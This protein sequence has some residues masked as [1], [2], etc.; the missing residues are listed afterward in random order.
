MDKSC[1]SC[2][3]YT[4]PSS[5]SGY[6]WISGVLLAVIPKCP[7]CVLAYSSTMMLCGEGSL[8]SSRSAHVS[9]LTIILTTLL[10]ILT[11][12]G[13]SLNNRGKRTFYALMIA[14]LGMSIL[15][16][17]VMLGGGELL[18]YTG[19]AIVFIAIWFNGSMLWFVKKLMKNK[20]ERKALI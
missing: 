4:K 9:P 15:F 11:L 16:S 18:Y 5:P 10:G 19:T 2:N 6:G 7:F 12:I 13:I 1:K 8:L 20:S 17:S 3:S 14:I